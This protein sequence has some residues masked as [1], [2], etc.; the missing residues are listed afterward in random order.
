M[1]RRHQLLLSK[2][3][4]FL[5]MEMPMDPT[6]E[7]IKSKKVLTWHDFEQLKTLRHQGRRALARYL[8]AILPARGSRAFQALLESLQEANAQHLVDLL[9]AQAGVDN[10]DQL[11]KTPPP[12]ARGDSAGAPPRTPT[13]TPL[14][15]GPD[16]HE[17]AV[18][19]A[20]NNK[21]IREFVDPSSI[22]PILAQNKV[23][24][25][26][27]ADMVLHLNGKNKKW[28][29]ILA[30]VLQRGERAYQ[31]FMAA[32]LQKGYSTMF[33]TIQETSTIASDSEQEMDVSDE[34]DSDENRT[35]E[36]IIAGKTLSKSTQ[37]SRRQ[38]LRAEEEA[39][40]ESDEEVREEAQKLVNSRNKSVLDA[41]S[42]TLAGAQPEDA[43]SQGSDRIPGNRSSSQGNHGRNSQARNSPK[44]SKSLSRNST[45][46]V[47]AGANNLSR[48]SAHPN[49]ASAEDTNSSHGGDASTKPGGSDVANGGQAG[50]SNAAKAQRRRSSV[51]S[52]L[53]SL[54]EEDETMHT[55]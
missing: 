54:Q 13:D 47:D 9:V 16:P 19:L 46:P 34:D 50:S 12:G 31:A 21:L 32:L 36:D 11:V 17:Y 48:N 52:N 28:D 55:Q 42:Q 22:S 6:L 14:P 35:Y 40:V 2:N 33:H 7:A 15:S 44:T 49:A 41:D 43:I 5:V 10:I 1:H 26:R 38:S 20:R 29:L 53:K 39:V 23:I 3:Y 51:T 25:P 8:L 4:E 30:A 37:V 27:E 18:R 24:T 45:H